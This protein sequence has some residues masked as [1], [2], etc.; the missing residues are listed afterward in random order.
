[1]L[2]AVLIL[3]SILFV[4]IAGAALIVLHAVNRLT[5]PK[6]RLVGGTPSDY[7]L[8]YEPVTFTSQ[9][10]TILRG[11]FIQSP[12]PRATIIFCHGHGGSKAPD[13]KYVP[14][15]R[16]Q[17]Y[18]VLLFDFR[19][20]GESDGD[21]TSLVYYERQDV[22]A[23]IA[24]L[25]QRGIHQVGL[26][27]F[28][29]GAAVAIATAP[30]SQAVRAVIADSAFAELRTIVNKGLRNR[31]IPQ[32]ISLPLTTLILW[33]AGHRLGCQLSDSDPLRWVGR[34]SP[35]PLLIIHGG[36]DRDVPVSEAHRLY[37]AAGEPK[38]L[39]IVEQAAHRNVDE[40]FPKEYLRR[41]LT[42]FDRWL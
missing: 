20:H 14:W 12:A 22:L 41:V 17:G 37:E 42:F 10:K 29:M 9:D 7:G 5:C 34:I 19:A 38:E 8:P 30:L 3:C 36:Q 11:W 6:R 31:H 16:E 4:I 24:Y 32:C 35:R 23:A 33:I 39:W 15:L 27:G 18:N 26:L 13:L 21:L 1:M 28:S 40:I 25:Q 2:A